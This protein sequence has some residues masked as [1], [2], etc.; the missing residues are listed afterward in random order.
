MFRA[1]DDD[2]KLWLKE[3]EPAPKAAE[4]SRGAAAPAPTA[5]REGAPGNA[6]DA[7]ERPAKPGKSSP[8]GSRA[9]TTT[10]TVPE[11]PNDYIRVTSQS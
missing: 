4:E 11:R 9:R 1:R 5:S 3:I 6:K 2:G 10:R 7:D 8:V